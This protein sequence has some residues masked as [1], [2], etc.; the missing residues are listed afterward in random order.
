[1][2]A[3]PP[4]MSPY[5]LPHPTQTHVQDLY[6]HCLESGTRAK[7]VSEIRGGFEIFTF[8]CRIPARKDKVSTAP[9]NVK[10]THVSRSRRLRNKRRRLAWLE[11]RNQHTNIHATA[12]PPPTHAAADQ[13]RLQTHEPTTTPPVARRTRAAKRRKLES[14]GASPENLRAS[15]L[16]AQELEI[17]QSPLSPRSLEIPSL[18]RAAIEAWSSPAEKAE[19]TTEDPSPD[20]K[21]SPSSVLSP[22]SPSTPAGRCRPAWSPKEVDTPTGACTPTLESPSPTSYAVVAALPRLPP[23]RLPEPYA[24]T[25]KLCGT[26]PVYKTTH[27]YYCEGCLSKNSYHVYLIFD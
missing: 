11:K 22:A 19:T 9:T 12:V 5:T 1:M 23:D 15:Q 25:C 18:E 10:K 17:P 6:R 3:T 13:A 7:L 24:R 8:T 20:H 21:L 14:P 16:D 26:S 4:A 2:T 27:G